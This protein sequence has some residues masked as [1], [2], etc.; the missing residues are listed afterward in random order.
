MKMRNRGN[1]MK[2]SFN[3]LII[4]SMIAVLIS[5]CSQDKNPLPSV[6]HPEDWNTIQSADFHGKKVLAASYES[7]KSCHGADFKGGTSGAGCYGSNCHTTYPH[8]AEWNY[9][10]NAKSH[11]E[12]IKSNLAALENCKKCHGS[13]LRGGTSNVSCYGC[14]AEGSLP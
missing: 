4:M 12:Y 5:Y 13:D 8:Q 7:C 2:S 10:D 6:S 14:H 1:P 9:F 3:V 11:G